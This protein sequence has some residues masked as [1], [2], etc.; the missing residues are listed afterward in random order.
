MLQY[1]CR[2]L[3]DLPDHEVVRDALNLFVHIRALEKASSKRRYEQTFYGRFL[4]IFS[5]SL[6]LTCLYLSL[7]K[8]ECFTMTFCSL[9]STLITTKYCQYSK[10]TSLMGIKELIHGKFIQFWQL[11][12]KVRN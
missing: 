3:H 9:P 7:E 2:K 1:C 12:F 4:L 8:N 6:M 11:I 5:L 10:N